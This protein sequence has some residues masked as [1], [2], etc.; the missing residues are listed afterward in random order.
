MPG[1]VV[2]KVLLDHLEGNGDLAARRH[3]IQKNHNEDRGKFCNRMSA[4]SEHDLETVLPDSPFHLSCHPQDLKENMAPPAT[5]VPPKKRKVRIVVNFACDLR[6]DLNNGVVTV[7]SLTLL[8][9]RP[10][11]GRRTIQGC[12]DECSAGQ[13][14]RDVRNPPQRRRRVQRRAVSEMK[15]R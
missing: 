8:S 1:G 13:R 5:T 15:D 2:R 7:D 4:R 9:D 3:F 14:V 11:R 12:L 10:R 6:S